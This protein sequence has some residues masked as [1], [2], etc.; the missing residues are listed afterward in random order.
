MFLRKFTLIIVAAMLCGFVSRTEAQTTSVFTTGLSQ[1][2]KIILSP[3]GNL[4]VTET[5]PMP[6]S[7]RVSIIDRHGNRRTLIDGLP[8]GMDPEGLSG[9]QGLDMQGFTL[10]VAIGN[11]DGTLAG[12]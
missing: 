12:L 4:L 5:M 10:F 3:S 7:G 2:S 1:P 8:S 9:P 6:N 11:S